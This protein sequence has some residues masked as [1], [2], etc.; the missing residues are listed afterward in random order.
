MQSGAPVGFWPEL[1]WL[2]NELHNEGSPHCKSSLFNNEGTCAHCWHNE[3]NN[4]PHARFQEIISP[5]KMP[6]SEYTSTVWVNGWSQ[7]TRTVLIFS[8]L[9]I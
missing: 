4:E 3:L 7:L 2:N 1:H 5:W 9:D 8:L 6:N